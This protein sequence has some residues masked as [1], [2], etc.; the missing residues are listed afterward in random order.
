MKSLIENLYS[1]EECNAIKKLYKDDPTTHRLLYKAFSDKIL[2]S[3]NIFI[4]SKPLDVL[5]FICMG[6]TFAKSEVECQ[7]VAVIVYR[8]LKSESPLPY[9]TEDTGI[10]FA[11]KTLI[12]LALFKAA[13]DR[14]T[15]LYGA[16]SPEYYRGISK[17]IFI[18]NNHK[19][20]SENHEKWENFLHELLLT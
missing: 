9:I 20:I 5:S 17:E 1:T 15:D 10:V 13:M 8:Q 2:T 4:E 11:E 14:R 3:S 19:D 7:T 6:S 12:S 18:K 16:P